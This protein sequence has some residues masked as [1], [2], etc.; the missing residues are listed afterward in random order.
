M[1]MGWTLIITF[2]LVSL[3][4]IV[5]NIIVCDIFW[6]GTYRQQEVQNGKVSIPGFV[7]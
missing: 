4:Q 3:P 7:Y 5:G 6:L 1:N 2:C